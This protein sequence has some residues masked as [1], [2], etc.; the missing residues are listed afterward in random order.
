MLNVFLSVMMILV[1]LK[2]FFFPRWYSHKYSHLFDFTGYNYLLGSVCILW[3]LLF[4]WLE[5]RKRKRRRQGKK[6]K[7]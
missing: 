3:G 1:G 6:E 7:G 2:L 4:L 5:I